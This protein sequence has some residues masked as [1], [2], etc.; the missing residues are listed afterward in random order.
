[1]F[2]RRG[3]VGAETAATIRARDK[4][5]SRYVYKLWLEGDKVSAYSE[6]KVPLVGDYSAGFVWSYVVRE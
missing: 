4:G 2:T 6:Y 3:P 1:M 5:D